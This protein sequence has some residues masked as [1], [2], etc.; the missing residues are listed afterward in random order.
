MRSRV[1]PSIVRST[2]VSCSALSLS[3]ALLAAAA[4]PSDRLAAA[5]DPPP[6]NSVMAPGS[7]AQ[8]ELA[9]A[10]AFVSGRYQTSDI[11]HSFRTKLGDTI[12]CIDF[13]AQPG[14]KALA[15]R[16]TPIET[17][18]PPAQN[19]QNSNTLFDASADE[20]GATRQCPDTTVPQ[21]RLTVDEIEKAGGIDAYLSHIKKFPFQLPRAQGGPPELG[22]P[23]YAHTYLPYTGGKNITSTQATLSIW[24]PTIAASDPSDHS[25]EQTWT[26]SLGNNW[27]ATKPCSPTCRQTVEAGWTVDPGLNGDT[28]PHL[29][30]YA[31]N[32]GY[33]T[34]CYNGFIPANV[35][36]SPTCASWIGL[37]SGIRRAYR[38]LPAP[39]LPTLIRRTCKHSR[40]GLVR[41][42]L[43]TNVV[44]DGK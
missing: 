3:V 8:A 24:T 31:T 40:Y 32:D 41:V 29:F 16:G 6:P 42:R 1:L 13:F 34:G 39:H 21:V 38:C 23:T 19:P 35:S 30:L 2:S 27:L 44:M 18:P 5:E 10:Q 37:P 17:L 12:D 7:P 36:G 43:T 22:L 14:V 20:N 15:A 26:T 9:R 33:Q 25:I 28:N 4:F 11:K